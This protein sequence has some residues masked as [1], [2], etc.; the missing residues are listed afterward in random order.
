MKIKN[1]LPGFALS[2]LIAWIARF[3]SSRMPIHLIGSA[4]IA[5]FIG[6]LLHP[7]IESRHYYKPGLKFTSKN[8]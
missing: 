6:M 5:L 4:I 7:F 8:T 3:I 2:L 1:I